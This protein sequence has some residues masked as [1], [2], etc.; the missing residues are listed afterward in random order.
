MYRYWIRTAHSRSIDRRGKTERL[1]RSQVHGDEEVG[2][3]KDQTYMLK[4]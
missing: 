1:E 3:V 2:R 4:R